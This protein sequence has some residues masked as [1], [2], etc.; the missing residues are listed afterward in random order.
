MGT[1]LEE[2]FERGDISNREFITAR[3]WGV[4]DTEP[5]LHDGRATTLYD[6]IEFHGGE[7]QA[8]R[9]HFVA[10]PPDRQDD[11]IHFLR[12]LRTPENPND[13]IAAILA[14]QRGLRKQLPGQRQRQRR[15][16]YGQRSGHIGTTSDLRGLQ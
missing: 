7:A 13:D 2:T 12:H 9:N 11:L 6:A 5:Y 8:A 4:A 14:T 3:L 1:R 16:G 15:D 10:L